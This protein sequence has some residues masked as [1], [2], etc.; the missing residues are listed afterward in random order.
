MQRYGSNGSSAR[1]ETSGLGGIILDLQEVVE[2]VPKSLE[3]L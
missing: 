1:L 2:D 3:R